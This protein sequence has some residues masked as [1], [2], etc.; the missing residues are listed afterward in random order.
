MKRRIAG[1]LALAAV[2]VLVSGSAASQEDDEPHHFYRQHWWRL[3]A[4]AS[5]VYY[6]DVDQGLA[7]R[8]D[9]Y[10]TNAAGALVPVNR[11]PFEAVFGT[12]HRLLL[13]GEGERDLW[14]G[15]G[16]VS[17]GVGASYAE[18]YGIGFHQTGGPNGGTIYVKS[19]DGTGFHLV[20]GKIFASYRFD[21][22]LRDGFPLVPYVKGGID[23]VVYWEQ[24]S[25]GQVTEGTNGSALGV[26][27]GLEGTAGLSFMLDWVDPQIARDMYTDLGIAH[28]FLTAGWTWQDIQNDPS[29]LVHQIL[30]GGQSGPKTLNLS[31]SFFN[32]GVEL[33]F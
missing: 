12:R 17:I 11:A 14:Q 27:T 13:E 22:F 8:S 29:N 28:T 32:F 2:A 10:D 25:S 4:R 3:S 19:S 7:P 26:V 5:T 24:L 6:P 30:H 16:T 9:L 15:F 23:G 18:F 21:Y 31:A 20:T 33:E 1:A